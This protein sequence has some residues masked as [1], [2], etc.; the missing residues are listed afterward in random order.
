MWPNPHQVDWAHMMVNMVLGCDWNGVF[1]DP[2][3]ITPG[4]PLPIPEINK[5][6]I[7]LGFQIPDNWQP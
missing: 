2:S 4:M 6:L 1:R 5:Y 3:Y 7:E